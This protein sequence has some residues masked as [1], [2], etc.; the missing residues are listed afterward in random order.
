M[1]QPDPMPVEELIKALQRVL[2][3]EPGAKVHRRPD[4]HLGIVNSA[5]KYAGLLP[6]P[7][8]PPETSIGLVD[9]P[10]GH[11]GRT[12]LE[13]ACD[14]ERI[15]DTARGWNDLPADLQARLLEGIAQ[16]DRGETIDRGDFSQYLTDDEVA[17][18]EE[19]NR[20]VAAKQDGA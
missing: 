7:P 15:T 19:I 10:C 14:A 2:L 12:D 11:L 3:V 18:V 4:G 13:H 17:L 6:L 9:L 8:M 16:S 20:D 1:D 5:G